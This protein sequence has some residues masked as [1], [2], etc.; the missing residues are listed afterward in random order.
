MKRR[1]SIIGLTAFL[2]VGIL[3]PYRV[4]L[5][6][7]LARAAASGDSRGVRALQKAGGD[8]NA[9]DLIGAPLVHIG[10]PV[11]VSAASRGDSDVVTA[12]LASGANP[13]LV[14]G[15]RR[16]ALSY[17][18]FNGHKQVVRALLDAGADP[19][20]GRSW[21][22]APR[23]AAARDQDGVL[24]LLLAHG[25][26]P[27]LTFGDS[28]SLLM[29]AARNGSTRAAALLL[30]RGADPCFGDAAALRL[31]RRE[32]HDGVVALLAGPTAACTR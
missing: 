10:T 26:D 24:D 28:T 31:A 7:G 12:L 15:K 23:G 21:I 8:P 19:N 32:R 11:L 3:I 1:L 27:S 22:P 29:I 9:S 25:V 4:L 14:D 2:A 6:V 13:G 20:D 17:A 5:S 30:A 16:T 18:A